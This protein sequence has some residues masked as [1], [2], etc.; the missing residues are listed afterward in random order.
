MCGDVT[1]D[2]NARCVFN[3]VESR[4]MCECKTGFVGNGEVCRAISKTIFT[5]AFCNLTS[6][7]NVF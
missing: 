5:I 6:L 3:D 1:C 7:I 4:P 2:V